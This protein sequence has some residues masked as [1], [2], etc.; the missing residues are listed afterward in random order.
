MNNIDRAYL[1]RRRVEIMD[2]C[3]LCHGRKPFCKCAYA[4]QFEYAKIRANIPIALRTFTLPD[5]THPQLQ[6]QK[7]AIME[8]I[9]GFKTQVINDNLYLYGSKGTGKSAMAAWILEEAMRTRRT[10]YFF[11]TLY[12]A[13][14]AATKLWD[15]IDRTA[16]DCKALKTA[17]VIVIDKI[18]EGIGISGPAFEELREVLRARTESGKVTIFVGSTKT[19][20]LVGNEK[21]LI[22]VCNCREIQFRGFD[23]K[24]EVLKEAEAKKGK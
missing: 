14:E 17:D 20:N 18:G 21:D 9:D 6:K 5:Y 3:P 10:G 13:K 4:F 12:A 15:R 8:Y 7:K 1:I 22:E 24:E 23:Y 2:N 16:D 19:D 11:H